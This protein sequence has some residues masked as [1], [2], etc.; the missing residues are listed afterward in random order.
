MRKYNETDNDEY[1]LRTNLL[2]I[3]S[4]EELEKAETL[5]FSL[6]SAELEHEHLPILFTL[7]GFK[8]LHYYLFQDVYSFAGQFRDVQ[9][10]KEG[11]IFKCL[12]N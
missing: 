11:T 3:N 4:I 1:L 7:E 6:R 9:L 8:D 5:A 10:A 12:C 2:G